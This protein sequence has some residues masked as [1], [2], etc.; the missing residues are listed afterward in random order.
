MKCFIQNYTIPYTAIGSSFTGDNFQNCDYTLYFTL[1]KMDFT[2]PNISGDY[3]DKPV[4][5][6]IIWNLLLNPS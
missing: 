3:N 1:Q 4:F 6:L 2:Y 5:T